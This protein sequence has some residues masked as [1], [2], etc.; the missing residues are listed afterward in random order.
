MALSNQRFALDLDDIERQLKETQLQSPAPKG[1]PLAELARIV[2]QSD[3]FKALL[4]ERPEAEPAPRPA[5]TPPLPP[6]RAAAD[7]HGRP[8]PYAASEPAYADAQ[9]DL[10][11][12]RPHRSRRGLVAVAVLLAAAIAGVSGFLVLRQRPVMTASGEPPIVEADTD[13][14]KIKPENPGGVEIPNQNAQVYERGGPD[15]QTKVV[16]REEQPIDVQQAARAA[17]SP[18][19]SIVPSTATPGNGSAGSVLQPSTSSAIVALG[20]PRRVRTVSVRPDGT[21]IGADQPASPQAAPAAPAA[22]AARPAPPPVA[23]TGAT[24]PAAPDLAS[25]P[26]PEARSTTPAT[27]PTAGVPTAAP[28][29]QLPAARPVPPAPPAASAAP[30]NGPPP[31]A[32]PAA[33]QPPPPQRTAAASLP[34]PAETTSAAGNFSVQLSV[35]NSEE[36]ARAQFRQLQ[37]KYAGELAGRAPLIRSA[38]VNGKTIYRV[39]VGPMS[40]D[41]A[42]ELCTKLKSSGAACFVAKN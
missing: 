13:P 7:P 26:R 39:R 38:E 1:D 24:Q 27:A 36:T 14:L 3:P 25:R 11:P 20:E 16:N 32:P 41:D 5:A 19:G 10:Q 15:T 18:A 21:I 17:Q 9:H 29:T 22:P 37:R 34:D 23:T 4:V 42:G 35:T 28:P 6:A 12:L 30:Q 8:A 33:Q 40:K 31:V 2:G